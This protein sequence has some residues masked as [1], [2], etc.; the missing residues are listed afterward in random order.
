MDA[1]Q[2]RVQ[3]TGREELQRTSGGTSPGGDAPFPL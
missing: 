2:A 3:R 1:D